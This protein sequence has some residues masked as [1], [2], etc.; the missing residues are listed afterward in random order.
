VAAE[1]GTKISPRTAL[2]LAAKVALSVALVAFLFRT[3]LDWADVRRA[4]EQASPSGLAL[5]FGMMLAS[6]VLGAFQWNRLLRAVGIETPFWKVC[7]HY[8]VGLFFNNF[9]PANVGGD[10]S[11]ILDASRGGNGSRA[12]AFS[13]VLMDRMVG[14]V[15]LGGLA[16]LTTLP[17]I[18]ELKLSNAWITT[19]YG[20][21]LGFFSIGVFM[22]WAVLNPR[23]LASLEGV[24]TRVGLGRL[25]P[26]LDEISERLASFRGQPRLFMEL[27]A[28]AAAVQVMRIAVHVLVAR[29]LGLH[30]AL[31]YFFLFVPLLAVIVSLPISL[32]G[33]GVREGAG[34]VLFGLVGV[35]HSMAFTLQF[36]TYLVALAV[37][38]IGGVVFLARIPYRRAESRVVRRPGE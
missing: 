19:F 22:F 9:L 33:I 32:N 1:P 16:V 31:P 18:G 3:R 35:S 23:A 24:L 17:A 34:V 20:G 11:R 26:A 2:L 8:H 6:N 25:K 13:T 15:A 21:V 12:R 14:T 30:V 37:S 38:L 7:S 27:F 5:A 28:I 10:F 29:A 36:T 4:I